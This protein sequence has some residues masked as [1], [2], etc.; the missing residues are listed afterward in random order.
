[1]AWRNHKSLFGISVTIPRSTVAF[2]HN[3]LPTDFSFQVFILDLII[4]ILCTKIEDCE[5]IEMPAWQVECKVEN[6]A[7][8]VN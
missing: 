1:M 4:S 7:L 2:P 8:L 6:I 5:A 3:N